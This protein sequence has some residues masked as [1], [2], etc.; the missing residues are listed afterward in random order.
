MVEKLFFVSFQNSKTAKSLLN[1]VFT[2]LRFGWNSQIRWSDFG[3]RFN[4]VGHNHWSKNKRGENHVNWPSLLYTTSFMICPDNLNSSF[5]AS[6]VHHNKNLPFSELINEPSVFG[7]CRGIAI[8]L[9]LQGIN[10]F[11]NLTISLSFFKKMEK[12]QYSNL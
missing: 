12:K 7:V 9:E 5:T 6:L 4:R 10:I 2:P 1:F 11:L 3:F 8:I